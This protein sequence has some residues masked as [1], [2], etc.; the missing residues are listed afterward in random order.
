MGNQVDV[1]KALGGVSTAD[2]HGGD[3][4]PTELSGELIEY[5]KWNSVGRNI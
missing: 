5:I 2:A 1:V 3:F 4:I